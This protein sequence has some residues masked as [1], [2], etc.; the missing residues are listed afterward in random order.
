MQ[1]PTGR[2]FVFQ[3]LK[4]YF[5]VR[6]LIFYDCEGSSQPIEHAKKYGIN[7]F[8]YEGHNL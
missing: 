4:L 8:D 6:A 5:N 3:W 7:I 1:I 2:R